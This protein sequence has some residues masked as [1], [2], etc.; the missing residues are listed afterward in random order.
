MRQAVWS[1]LDQLFGERDRVLELNCGTGEDAIHLARRGVRVVA[2]DVSE[3][4]LEMAREKVA[5]AKV[6]NLVWLHRM[7]LEQVGSGD[8]PDSK[9]GLVAGPFDGAFSNFGGL[10]CV[11]DLSKVALGLGQ[12]LRPR[13]RLALCI[14]GPIVPLE[15]IW[16]V[17]HGRPRTAFRRL[18]RGGAHWRGIVVRY[19][20]I[21]TVR[22]AFHPVFRLL[23]ANAI[24]ALLPP[25][26]V[27]PMARIFPRIIQA[28]YWCERRLETRWPLPWL[29]DHY[30]LEFERAVGG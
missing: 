9:E 8:L 14:M 5:T 29:A 27:E 4:M 16:F 21:K 17:A 3:D 18:R 19:P 15:W 22:T 7:A 10:N 30:L 26:Y 6:A 24:G 28:L 13:A 1:R 12:L 25:P 23:R 2:T 20:S 11:E